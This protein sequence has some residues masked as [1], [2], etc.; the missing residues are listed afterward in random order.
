MCHGLPSSVRILGSL[1]RFKL[2]QEEGEAILKRLKPSSDS[3]ENVNFVPNFGLLE[4][5]K[6]CLAYCYIFPPD[7]EFEMEKLVLL[8]MAEGFLKPQPITVR[9]A[10]S[11]TNNEL[12]PF[13]QKSS[14]NESSFRMCM[15][16]LADYGS[17]RY[18]FRLEDNHPS[19]IPLN[20]RY[21]SLVGG[22]YENSVIFEAID[23]AKLLRTFLPLDHESRHL[24]AT[25]PQ[26]LLSKLQFLQVLSLSLYHITEIPDSIGNLEHL[27]YIDHSHTN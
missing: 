23:R 11:S 14:R 25:E 22:K 2:Q 4:G 6:R 24:C 16:N 3:R 17:T 13:F 12:K 1:L 10:S 27:R 19:Q 21:L 5:L 18:C 8:C 7:Y 15:N 9:G 26:N 20:T